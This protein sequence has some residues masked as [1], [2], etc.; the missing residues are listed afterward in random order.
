ME[1]RVRELV[2]PRRPSAG[3]RGGHAA[4]CRHRRCV[5]GEPVQMRR[6]WW[7]VWRGFT[8]KYNLQL[9][10]HL[11]WQQ[12]E[13]LAEARNTWTETRLGKQTG[14]SD[15]R[16]HM[17]KIL[18]FVLNVFTWATVL[19]YR[20]RRRQL[21]KPHCLNMLH[22]QKIQTPR[23]DGSHSLR[24]FSCNSENQSANATKCLLA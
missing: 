4:L 18:M 9:E 1:E 6:K 24:P 5:W 22:Q 8:D 23:P 13:M 10:R 21:S 19:S 2:G 7:A 15:L 14:M 3:R 12:T 16:Y 11:H 20:F 17:Q